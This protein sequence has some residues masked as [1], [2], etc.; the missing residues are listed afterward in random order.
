[1]H[2]TELR[3][4]IDKLG[5][6]MMPEHVRNF[7]ITSQSGIPVDAA[8]S[9]VHHN[10]S[11]PRAEMNLIARRNDPMSQTVKPNEPPSEDW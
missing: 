11:I 7:T 2:P 6:K 3:T 1:V 4:A 8:N 5:E 9:V 10:V